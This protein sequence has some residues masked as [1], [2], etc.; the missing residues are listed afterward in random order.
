MTRFIEQFGWFR[1]RYHSDFAELLSI[2]NEL[3]GQVQSVVGISLLDD[4]KQYTA[5]YR[6]KDIAQTVTFSVCRNEPF[7]GK[8][9]D[10]FSISLDY[11]NVYSDI[12]LYGHWRRV[13]D[14]ITDALLCWRPQRIGSVT[15]TGGW[16][17][18]QWCNKTQRQYNI[19]NGLPWEENNHIAEPYVYPLDGTASQ[20]WQLYDC[21]NKPESKC[22]LAYQ[23]YPNTQMPYIPIDKTPQD[24]VGKVPYLQSKNKKRFFIFSGASFEIHP[25]SDCPFVTSNYIYLDEEVFFNFRHFHSYFG[26]LGGRV[27]NYGFRHYPPKRDCWA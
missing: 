26:E 27:S 7:A 4:D 16:V 1:F 11:E 19:I 13:D 2:T 18:G 15:V 6:D 8:L 5:V 9:S 3:T 14:F 23:F 21:N 22:K 20:S 12:P 17:G 10:Y 24:F 25:Y